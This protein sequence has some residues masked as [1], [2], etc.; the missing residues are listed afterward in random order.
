MTKKEVEGLKRNPFFVALNPKENGSDYVES[1]LKDSFK[2][3]G[4]SNDALY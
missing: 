2:Y 3:D 1:V 4:Q